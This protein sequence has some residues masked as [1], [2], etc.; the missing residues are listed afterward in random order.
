VNIAI[1]GA[2]SVGRALATGFVGAGHSV[3]FVAKH[4]DHAEDAAAE[5][6]ANAAASITDAVR[7]AELIVLAIPAL[8]RVEII[9][10]LRAAP[11]GAAIVDATNVIDSERTGLTTGRSGAQDLQ[12]MLPDTPVVKAFNSVFATVQ[13]HPVVDGIQLDGFYAGDDEKAKA[14]VRDLLS[15]MGYRPID[16]GPLQMARALEELGLLMVRLAADSGWKWKPSWK[17]LG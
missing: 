12:E 17:L 9:E 11:D 1:V 10:G 16:A 6:G 13:S 4:P 14:K 3:T 8:A 15:D 2:G 7:D 5:I